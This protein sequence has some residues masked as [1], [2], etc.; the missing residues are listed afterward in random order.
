MF[1]PRTYK[2]GSGGG[3]QS[4]FLE[5]KT[6]PPDVFSRFSFI[7]YVYARFETSVVMVNCFGYTV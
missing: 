6:S 4:Y 2:G 5:D 1:N 7:P 3:F